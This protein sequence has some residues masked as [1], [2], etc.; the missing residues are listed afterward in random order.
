MA[1]S[2]RTAT[3]TAIAAASAPLDIPDFFEGD[4]VGEFVADDEEEAEDDDPVVVINEA[5]GDPEELELVAR[6]T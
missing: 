4:C 1:A 2:A 3:G 5:D 6:P